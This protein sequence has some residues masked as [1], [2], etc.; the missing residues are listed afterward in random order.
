MKIPQNAWWHGNY[1]TWVDA[2]RAAQRVFML[3]RYYARRSWH[4]WLHA[5][6]HRDH[7]DWEVWAR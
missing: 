4:I 6:R 3:G 2:S 1:H 7:W 5:H